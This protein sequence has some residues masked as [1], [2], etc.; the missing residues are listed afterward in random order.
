M[1]WRSKFF[2]PQPFEEKLQKAFLLCL[3]HKTVFWIPLQP[4][5]LSKNYRLL[6]PTSCRCLTL[7]V[8]NFGTVNSY[9]LPKLKLSVAVN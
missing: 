7:A 2:Q 9:H 6:T 8:D 4:S 5:T 1:P 3:T